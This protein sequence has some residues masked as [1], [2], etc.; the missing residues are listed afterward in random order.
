MS[1][2]YTH[3]ATLSIAV[4]G[5]AGRSAKDIFAAGVLDTGLFTGPRRVGSSFDAGV[6]VGG[7]FEMAR[8]ALGAEDARGEGGGEG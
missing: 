4:T 6:R 3:N 7:L 8:F 5:L 1:Q 2:L